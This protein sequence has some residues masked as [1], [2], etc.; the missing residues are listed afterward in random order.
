MQCFLP[1]LAG[2]Q[3][4]EDTGWIRRISIRRWQ[5]ITMKARREGSFLEGVSMLGMEDSCDYEEP[6]T[7]RA[8]TWVKDA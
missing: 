2:T 4:R 7:R 8:H 5:G 1:D 3:R 6:M